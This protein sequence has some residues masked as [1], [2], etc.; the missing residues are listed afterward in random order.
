MSTKAVS[1]AIHSFRVDNPQ[2]KLILILLAENADENGVCWPSQKAT[3]DKA[4]CSLST[5]KRVQRLLE[6]HGVITVIRKRAGEQKTKNVYRLRLETSF[7][8]GT[9][10]GEEFCEA[11]GV[12]ETPSKSGDLTAREI[13]GIRDSE[14]SEGVTETPSNP[15]G[16]TETPSD[17]RRGHRDPFEGVTAMTPEPSYKPSVFNNNNGE[18]LNRS[19]ADRFPLT[20]DWQPSDHVFG[21]L[22]VRGIPEKFIA[23]QLDPFRTYWVNEGTQRHQGG[24]DTSFMA[25]VRRQWEY[26]KGKPGRQG[27][28]VDRL[29]DRSWTED[30]T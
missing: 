3:A 29:T 19:R 21:Q 30:V 22:T 23:D 9:K 24:W 27:D 7:T 6:R 15:E 5:V 16:V 20:L 10:K 13:Q 2:V 12:T 4:G 26:D 11:E 1:W 18:V 14:I 28:I 25:Q 17:G 8:L